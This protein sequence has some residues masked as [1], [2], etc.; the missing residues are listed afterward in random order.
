MQ[1]RKLLEQNEKN[2]V[3]RK[4]RSYSDNEALIYE[5]RKHIAECALKLFL[6]QGYKAT[7][8]RQIARECG[9]SEAN[10]YR[11]IGCK[12]D[13]LHLIATQKS[14]LIDMLRSYL[15]KLGNVSK[16]EALR[17]CIAEYFRTQDVA[18]DYLF[19]FNRE[20]GYFS[21]E[22]RR[23]LLKGQTEVQSFFEQLLQEGVN[24]GEFQVD[25]PVLLSH[26]IL[27]AG[28]DWVV[29]GWF[30]RRHY[31]LKEYTEKQT[32]MILRLIL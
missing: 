27:M 12:D 32:Q 9:M 8:T 24:A 4:I 28:H 21:R 22:D 5:R 6:N 23:T 19:F 16:A 30:L 14:S 1:Y 18:S 31:T 2:M 15:H 11:Y 13:I 17:A 7:T 29:R 26:N 20:I 10:V 25:E 3:E